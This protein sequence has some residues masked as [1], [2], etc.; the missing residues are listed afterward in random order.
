M[1]V[2]VVLMSILS[3]IDHPNIVPVSN[4]IDINDVLYIFMDYCKNGDLLEYIRKHGP[5]N[6][7]KTKKYFR[8]IVDAVQY[9]HNC[10]IAHRDLKCENILLTQDDKVKLG[11]FG[12]ARNCTDKLTG[13]KTFSTTY[14]G[15]AAYAAPEILQGIP[16]DP[17]MYDIWSIGCIL[18]IMLSAAMPFDDSN[19]KKMLK[20][21]LEK[22][23]YLT[24]I[25]FWRA[26][27]PNLIELFS[28]ILEPDASRRYTINDVA[29]CKWLKEI[30]CA[31]Q[32]SISLLP[33]FNTKNSKLIK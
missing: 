22:T 32:K 21:Q 7:I 9:L 3:A 30:V 10:N 14:C 28:N 17:K 16:Y 11:D 24:T 31:R 26:K 20:S 5:L 19:I 8:Q 2:C 1:D 4:I 13:K 15:S 12:F 6:Q 25:C 33:V 23:A 18:F 27:S 29:N